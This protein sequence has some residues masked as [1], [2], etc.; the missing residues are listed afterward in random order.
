MK[1]TEFNDRFETDKLYEIEKLKNQ[2]TF[3]EKLQTQGAQVGIISGEQQSKLDDILS[4]N[5]KYLKKLET[6]EFE[7]AIVGLEKAGKSTFAN[8][9]IENNVLPSAP[10][11]C[12]FTSTRLVYGND[13]AVV[14]FYK[15]DEFQDI[16]RQLLKEV[17]YPNW[18]KESFK[19]LSFDKFESFFAQLENT[20]PNLHKNHAGTTDKEIEDILKCKN[21]LILTGGVKEFSGDELSTDNFQSYIKGENK[22]DDTSKPR[23]VKRIEIESSKLQKLNTAVI[24]DVPGFDSPTKIHERQTIERLKAADAIILLTNVGRNP[25]LVGTQLNII[26]TNADADGIPLRDKLFVFGNQLDTANSKEESVN[27][28]GVLRKDVKKYKIGED[29]RVFTGSALKYLVDSKIKHDVSI[30]FDLETSGIT[31]IRE[32]LIRYYENERFEILKRKIEKNRY[33]LKIMFKQIL[34]AETEAFD[35]NFAENEKNR[36]TR[37]SYKEIEHRLQKSLEELKFDFKN[38]IWDESYFSNKFKE[39]VA[40]LSYFSEI[41]D[42]AIKQAKLSEDDSLT[43]DTPVEKMNIAIRKKLHID[44][45]HQFSKLINEMTDE[46]SRD[47][48]IRLL[49]TFTSS[50]LGNDSPHLFDVVE[51]E[52]DKFIKRITKD[53]A[54]NDGRFVYLIERFSRDIFD[55]L[56]SY[57]L[58]SGD[59]TKKFKSAESEFSYLDH[60]YSSGKDTLIHLILSGYKNSALNIDNAMSLV[61]ELLKYTASPNGLATKIPEITKIAMELK[62]NYQ[63]GKKSIYNVDE[64]VKEERRCKTEQDI[65][66]EINND[67]VNLRDILQTAV[68]PA[69]NLELAFYNGVDKQIKLLLDSFKGYGTDNSSK[70]DDFI[71]KMVTRVKDRELSSINEKIENNRIKQLFIE[72]MKDFHI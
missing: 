63:G 36:I 45:L 17:N 49:R 9:L 35:D 40:N 56:I 24:Y 19:S 58:S 59:R 64:L 1:M 6:N 54:H 13:K 50:I 12:T 44:F 22:G 48:E 55:V 72:D 11:R 67:I 21:K 7:I 69:V 37:S 31:E 33:D 39:D 70:F 57:P 68:V 23:S 10:E 15:E 3:L 27:N 38:E 29:K 20:D 28:I 18:E 61:T 52:S 14:E 5:K 4:S 65:L 16:F 60:Y 41:T 46:K 8:A 26:T 32:E 42:D 53:I 34:D 2:N 71:S 51:A 66:T 30:S 62:K 25:S 47:V 43:K